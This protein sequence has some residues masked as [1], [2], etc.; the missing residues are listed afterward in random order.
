MIKCFENVKIMLLG[1]DNSKI[2]SL[3]ELINKNNGIVTTKIEESEVI[4]AK[5]NLLTVKE[6][7]LINKYEN[8]I[9]TE[10]WIND[11]IE[12]NKFLSLNNYKYRI[13]ILKHEYEKCESIY[14]DKDIKSLNYIL[15]KLIF[16]VSDDFEKETKMM[17]QKT[18]SL[19]GGIYYYKLTPLTTHIICSSINESLTQ[20]F[21]FKPIQVNQNW[22][23]DCINQEK[24]LAPEEYK[25]ISSFYSSLITMENSSKHNLLKNYVGRLHST[26]FKGVIFY[27]CPDSYSTNEKNCIEEDILQ[28]GGEVIKPTTNVEKL[29][30][31]KFIIVNDGDNK[32][33]EFLS[34]R[35]DHYQMVISHRYIS[36]CI[37]K[38]LVVDLQKTKYVH[39]MPFPHKVPFEDFKGVCIYF[40]GFD[41][42]EK[43]VFEH[44][45]E[46]L[47]G[48]CD[49][50]E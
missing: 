12:Q 23:F 49:L 27:I 7:E 14:K 3:T 34:L 20:D 11:S 5:E 13:Y 48:H 38:R 31:A 44:L 8:K 33:S 2:K 43:T 36:F 26:L 28:N 29:K 32:S 6:N 15:N 40:Q 22:I 24:I 9:V 41:L 21:F 46:T 39:L 10:N 50:N 37:E 30:K 35:Q 4:I 17:L 42:M 18:I 47:G 25:P 1:F 45:T 16:F 19:G